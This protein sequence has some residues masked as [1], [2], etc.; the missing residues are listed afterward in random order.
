MV[1]AIH[2]E[3][4]REAHGWHLTLVLPRWMILAWEEQIFRRGFGDVLCSWASGRRPHA[5][6]H[7]ALRCQGL[8][9]CQRTGHRPLNFGRLRPVMG[10]CPTVSKGVMSPRGGMNK[11][12][13]PKAH[14][15]ILQEIQ[16]ECCLAPEIKWYYTCGLLLHRGTL[17]ASPEYIYFLMRHKWPESW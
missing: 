10:M 8:S 15:S 7:S 14:V 6:T 16:D 5:C 9:M 3:A 12:K 11:T 2:M 4:L 1:Q 13:C 17:L